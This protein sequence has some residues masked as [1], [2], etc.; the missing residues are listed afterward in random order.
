MSPQTGGFEMTTLRPLPRTV[1]VGLQLA[2][3][4]AVILLI[5]PFLGIF[6]FVARIVA[7][8]IVPVFLLSLALSPRL[9]AWLDG[10]EQAA[11]SD[12]VATPPAGMMLHPAHGWARIDGLDR[13]QVGADD[14]APLLLGQVDRVALPAVG[15]EVTQGEPLFAVYHNA[16]HIT[17]RAPLSG[18]VVATNVALTTDP[19]LASRA[20]FG[21]GW[22]VTLRPSALAREKRA[23]TPV[24][25]AGQWVRREADRVIAGLQDPAF[26][27]M[28]DGGE[29]SDDLHHHLDD[30]AFARIKRELFADPS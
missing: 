5:V 2:L 18:T 26:V 4:A 17:L 10:D 1:V 29:L 12:A 28:Q 7:L 21:D 14:F 23:L 25:R 9:R 8:A 19:G 20:P 27:T 11:H 3:L 13:V 15:A 24:A 30:D 6:A 16:R 22:A